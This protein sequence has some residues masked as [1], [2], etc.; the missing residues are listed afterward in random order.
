MIE[1]DYKPLYDIWV[2]TPG[3]D[4]TRADSQK[5]YRSFL[6]RNPGFSIT[7]EQDGKLVGG[8]LCGHDGR[9]GFIHHLVVIPAVR[10]QGVGKQLVADCLKKL[11]NAGIEKCHLFI[12]RDNIN[13]LKFW[14]SI[15][16]M[17]RLELTMASYI[18]DP[19]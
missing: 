11:E 18:F 19:T 8:V 6:E 1:S 12:R 10:R 5:G 14:E 9:R 17:E 7:A 15:G 2:S 16:W 4:V 13:G 3:V